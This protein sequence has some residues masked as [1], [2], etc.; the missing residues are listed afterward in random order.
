[1]FKEC[2]NMTPSAGAITSQQG[3]GKAWILRQFML[4][5]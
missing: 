5:L 3:I 4:D 1:M 2:F